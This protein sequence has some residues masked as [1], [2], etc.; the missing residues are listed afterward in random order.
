[1][2]AYIYLLGNTGSTGKYRA[3]FYP[4][5]HKMPLHPSPL[6]PIIIGK[7]LKE[8]LLNDGALASFGSH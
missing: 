6:A 2:A 3:I 1:L 7:S 5:S 4:L 8:N